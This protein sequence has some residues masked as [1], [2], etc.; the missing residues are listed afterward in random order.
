ML[1]IFSYHMYFVGSVCS[2]SVRSRSMGRARDQPTFGLTRSSTCSGQF[3][4]VQFSSC[5]VNKA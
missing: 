2:Q 3:C 4:S 5:T 1:A